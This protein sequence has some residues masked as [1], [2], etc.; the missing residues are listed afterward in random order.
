MIS[1][2]I[3]HRLFCLILLCFVPATSRAA[4]PAENWV[5]T[6]AT[7]P[8]SASNTEMKLGETD[9]T[10]RQI[11]HVS[12]GGSRLRIVLTNEF[13][14][15]PLRVQSAHVALSTGGSEIGLASAN[16]LTF[17]GREAI[18]IPPGASAISDPADLKFPPLSDLAISLFIPA[19]PIHSRSFHGFADQTNY[20]T[21]ENVVGQK[22]FSD[23]RTFE[24][25]EFLKGVDVVAPES[26]GAIVCFGDSI[27]DGALSTKNANARWPDVLARRVQADKKLRA[28]SVLNEGIGGNR[29]L[30]D[31]T[32][33]NALARFDRD[34]LTHPGV[35]YFIFMEGINDIGNATNPKGGKDPITAEE[36]IAG[37]QQMVERAHTHGIKA[38]GATLTPFVGAGYQ[39]AEGEKIRVAVNGWIRT[40]KAL[41]GVV[42][43]DLATRDPSNPA[44]FS[45]TADSGDHLHPG[46]AG[47]KAMGDSIDLPRLFAK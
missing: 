22:K 28:L 26:A 7:A 32:G 42:D 1:G 37:L 15:D 6:W 2:S 41:D 30:H 3:P 8:Y 12:L 23:A 10:L 17:S 16:A 40:N 27:T 31:G 35:K 38:I 25:W 33:P 34:V 14:S 9:M 45:K 13:G 24:S 43:F 47:Y 18:T 19:Q 11:V 29:V 21:P 20:M 5:G 4:A 36:L 44:V 39:S 46:D